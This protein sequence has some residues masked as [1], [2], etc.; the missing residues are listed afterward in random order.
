MIQ[1]ELDA[2]KQSVCELGFSQRINNILLREGIYT[3]DALLALDSL[4]KLKV[5]RGFGVK[6]RDELLSK[7]REHG[8]DDWVDRMELDIEHRRL[9]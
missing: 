2:R 7:M 9:F 6:S 5:R 8:Y 4:D 1:A 3:V